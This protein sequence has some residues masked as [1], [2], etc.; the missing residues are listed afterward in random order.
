VQSQ[1]SPAGPFALGVVLLAA[2]ASRRMGTAKLLLPWGNTSILGHL[3]AQWRELRASQ[4]AV[5]CAGDNGVLEAELDRLGLAPE[6]RIRNPAPEQG[7]FSSIRC[8]ARW[9]GWR[10]ALTHWAIVLGDQPHVR[11]QTLQQ[12][13]QQSAAQPAQVC[14][15]ARHGH[16]RHPVILPREQF[17]QLGGT[18]ATTLK[19]FLAA[20]GAVSRCESDDAGLD[21]DI[22]LP[23]DY[24]RALKLAGL[25]R[26]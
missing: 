22:D 12:V 20:A 19:E 9:H 6:D 5:V 21:L 16:G 3:I 26:S 7:M 1:P 11:L 2:G 4:I 13:L 10:P 15:P 8:A 25:A 17:Q 24:E 23:G 18:P 14:Q